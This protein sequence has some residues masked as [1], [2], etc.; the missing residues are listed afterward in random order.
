MTQTIATCFCRVNSNEPVLWSVAG[1]Y[2]SGMT[3]EEFRL[4]NLKALVAEFGSIVAVAERADTA[5]PYLSQIINRVPSRTGKPRD[6]GPDLARKLEAGCD[7]PIG[8]MDI[9]HSASTL[10]PEDAR[11]ISEIQQDVAVYAVPDHIKQAILT[12]ISSTPKKEN[13][14][15]NNDATKTSPPD[16]GH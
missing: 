6:V 10:P 12:L 11:F 4:E 3:A 1:C 9:D 14:P 7:K 16:T 2:C 15:G 13:T 5:A 8:W